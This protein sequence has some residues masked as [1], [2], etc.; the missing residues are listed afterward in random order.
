MDL[1][2]FEKMNE[3][4]LRNYLTF[5][6]WHYRVMD[7]FWFIYVGDTYGQEQAERI[8]EAVWSRVPELGTRDLLQ[9]FDIKE[10][11][12]KGFTKVLKLFPW[13]ILVGYQ[14][15]EKED[16]VIVTIPHCPTQEARLRRGLGEFVCKYMHHGEFESIARA[17]DPSIKVECLFA[18]PDEHPADCFCKWRFTQAS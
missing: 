11:G 7:A 18:P 2:A 9:R 16:E 14:F 5:L 1:S 4:E 15:E 3:D 17:V 10:R 8:N 13:T 12:L 6:L